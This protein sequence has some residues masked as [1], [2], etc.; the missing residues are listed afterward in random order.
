M[1]GLC[2]G[3]DKEVGLGSGI[4]DRISDGEVICEIIFECLKSGT[5]DYM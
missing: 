5:G 2:G 3:K 1:R 4:W